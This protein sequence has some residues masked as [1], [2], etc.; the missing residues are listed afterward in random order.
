MSLI[1]EILAEMVG[2]FVGDARLTLAILALVG[3]VAALTRL[4]GIDPLLAGAVLTVGCL[5]VLIENVRST[6]RTK[7]GS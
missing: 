6:A 7:A 1:K 2:M 3:A 5:A 4:A